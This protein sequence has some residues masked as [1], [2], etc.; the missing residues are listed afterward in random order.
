MSTLYETCIP[1]P[2]GKL[3]LVADDTSLVRVHFG[4]SKKRDTSKVLTKATRELEE[5]FAGKR[6]RFTLPLSFA[7]TKLQEKVWKALAEIPFGETRSYA[8][9][10]KRVGSPRAFRAVGNCNNKN[11]LPIVLPC[12]R[13]IGSNGSLTGFGGGIPMKRWLLDHESKGLIRPR[14]RGRDS[15]EKRR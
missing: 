5:Y 15:S 10:A 8:D 4:A 1:S 12:H 3:T 2:I 11:P 7:G 6:T 13:V 14:A 9:I